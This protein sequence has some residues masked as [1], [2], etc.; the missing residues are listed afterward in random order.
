MS[1]YLDYVK[2]KGSSL[3]PVSLIWKGF[4]IGSWATYLREKHRKGKLEPAV[5]NRLTN[6]GFHW[7]LKYDGPGIYLPLLKQYV[8]REG[9]AN[10]AQ[11]HKED[12]QPLGAWLGNQRANRSKL[13]NQLVRELTALGFDWNPAATKWD[14]GMRALRSFKA[15]EN[16]CDVPYKHIEQGFDLGQWIAYARSHKAR[17]VRGALSLER[18]R[19]L[20]ALGFNWSV[21][22]SQQD[23]AWATGY[24]LLKQ[25]VARTGSSLIART[26][27]VGTYPLGA[28]VA[29]QRAARRSGILT[30]VRSKKLDTLPGWTWEVKSGPRRFTSESEDNWRLGLKAF[31]AFIKRKRHSEVPTEH[32]EDGFPL[33]KWVLQMRKIRMQHSV[34]KN[35]EERISILDG[36]GFL[37]NA[38]EV[39]R[40]RAWQHGLSWLREYNN[41]FGTPRVPARYRIRGYQLGAWVAEQRV[42][43]REGKLSSNRL[44]ILQ[45]IAGWTWTPESGRRK[46]QS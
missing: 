17:S 22:S 29:K 21:R 9:N 37:W 44:G 20:D 42:R 23:A 15:R 32:I 27:T 18:I 38:Q 14:N 30:D 2:S 40:E 31:R 36:L 45:A 34:S 3:V 43:Y 25:Y 12:G 1:L 26:E 11:K 24:E 7:D 13:P 46:G 19:Q 4:P 28:W 5:A 16:H 41:R 10:V 6:A 8:Q 39:Q 35:H 33:G